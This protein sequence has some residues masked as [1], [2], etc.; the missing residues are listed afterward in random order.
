MH[1][2]VLTLILGCAAAAPAAWAQGIE[3]SQAAGPQRLAKSAAKKA[4]PS[5]PTTVATAAP[6]T[7]SAAADA[8]DPALEGAIIGALGIE[9][10]VRQFDTLC[11]STLPTSMRRYGGAADGWRQRNETLVARA[12]LALERQYGSAMRGTVSEAINRRNADTMA[13][14]R[15]APTFQRINWCDQTADA[16]TSG[17]MDLQGKPNIAQPLLA[18]RAR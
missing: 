16:V 12:R 11:V 9:N 5:E 2:L 8:T 1:R 3:A 14:V 13:P 4:L 18:W 6:A 17:S 10:L 15:Q 7:A